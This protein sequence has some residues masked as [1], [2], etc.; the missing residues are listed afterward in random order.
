M[1]EL[2][3]QAMLTSGGLTRL[4]DRLERDGLIVRARCVDDLRGYQARITDQGRSTLRRANE[5]QIADVCASCS[6]TT[7]RRPTSRS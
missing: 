2:A 3:E 6:S 7:S 4:A 1:S 5:H